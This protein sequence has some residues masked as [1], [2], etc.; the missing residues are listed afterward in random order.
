MLWSAWPSPD[1]KPWG[2]R[3]ISD[4]PLLMRLPGGALPTA[5]AELRIVE[6]AD[7]ATLA[8]FEAG[9]HRWLPRAGHA[10]GP[11]RRIAR[12][13]HPRRTVAPL[14]RLPGRPPGHHGAVACRPGR[15]RDLRRINPAHRARSW[16]RHGD[17][18]AGNRGLPVAGRAR[19]Q[20]P[21]LPD[22]PAPGL[23][24]HRAEYPLGE[25]AGVTRRGGVSDIVPGLLHSSSS[26]T[27]ISPP[28]RQRSITCRRRSPQWG[29]QSAGSTLAVRQRVP[30]VL[31]TE[32]CPPVLAV[33]LIRRRHEH[34]PATAS[35]VCGAL[36]QAWTRCRVR[37]IDRVL[38]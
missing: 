22:L 34:A 17:H 38:W 14:G 31:D 3:L 1:P 13:A 15:K 6:V 5:P 21:G 36:H 25:G 29:R 2:F 10:A 23:Q 20:R 11:C 12:R 27:S 28:A 18:R 30:S 9:V 16:V 4:M 19:G 26:I 33:W 37:L 24:R 8:D 35:A 32:R 7:A